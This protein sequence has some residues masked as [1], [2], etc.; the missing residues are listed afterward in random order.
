MS[1]E[2]VERVR[3]VVELFNSRDRRAIAS[4]HEDVQFTSAFTERKTFHGLDGMREYAADLVDELAL[5]G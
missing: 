3:Q 1:Q 4:F 5:R 2:N